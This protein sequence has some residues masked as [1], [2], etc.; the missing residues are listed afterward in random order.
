MSG[1]GLGLRG[2]GRNRGHSQWRWCST[3]H[4]ARLFAAQVLR[5]GGLGA[6]S[7][8]D[9]CPGDRWRQSKA[10]LHLGSRNRKTR[11]II[12]ESVSTEPCTT[13]D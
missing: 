12:K 6:E 2:G 10:M 11:V 4:S 7:L 1:L 8:G 5:V 13:S 3:C 9:E